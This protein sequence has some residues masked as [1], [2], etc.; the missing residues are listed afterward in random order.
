MMSGPVRWST[1]AS[2][3][4]GL[5]LA[6][7]GPP[8]AAEAPAFETA[9]L[10][11]VVA[12][13]EDPGLEPLDEA[14]VKAGL[15]H[16]ADE[17][18]RRFDVAPPRFT[19]DGRFD[20]KGFLTKYANPDDPLCRSEFAARYR[21]TGPAELKPFRERA[22]K[23]FRR[24]PL[25]SLRGF[26]AEEERGGIE[27]YDDVYEAYARQYV[28]RVELLEGLR[29]ASGAPLI[30]P[31]R[32]YERSF[33]AWLCALERQ[34]DYDVVI[35]N[36]FILQDLL[37]EPHPHSVFG[38][39]KIGGIATRAGG[40]AA[41]GGQALLATTFGFDTEIAE[42][43]E[44]GGRPLTPAL[45][46]R[47][48]GAYLLAHEIAHAT[49]GIPD[50]YDH[51]KGCLMT[52][53]PGATY[54]DGL[55]ELEATPRPCPKCRPY[56]RARSLLDRGEAALAAGRPEE[57]ARLLLES[58]RATP[59]H[60]HGSRRKRL[61]RV[62]VA[63]SKAHAS[64]GRRQRALRYARAAQK[65]DP[66]SS[67]AQAQIEALLLPLGPGERAVIVSRTAS[68]ATVAAPR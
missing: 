60:F 56:V 16:A 14:L 31:E 42:L 5:C 18:A 9:P 67:A 47:L 26:V 3:A 57:A 32:S 17:Y 49:F 30:R 55:R 27:G 58:A 50:V 20:V 40:R 6:L 28:A 34:H 38:K 53:R 66:R 54:L 41:L 13:V 2:W 65:L 12:V 7:F 45:R 68:T 52:T 44:I 59:E 19:L 36:A 23:F 15:R 35:T 46:A 10:E 51:P 39:A 43:N 1:R 29:T 25:E 8:A 62:T 21:G 11:L 48:L 33:V 63:A 64:L 37:T 4:S 24:W 61:A 22:L